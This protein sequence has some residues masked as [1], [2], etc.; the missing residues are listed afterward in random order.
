MREGWAKIPSLLKI[1]TPPRLPPERVVSTEQLPETRAEVAPVTRPPR[2]LSSGSRTDTQ[3]LHLEFWTQFHRYMQSRNATIQIS[4]PSHH[5]YSHAPLGR[6]NFQLSLVNDMAGGRTRLH[7]DVNGPLRDERFARLK[8]KHKDEL[9]AK[10]GKLKW[11]DQPPQVRVERLSTP[12]A[13]STWPELNVWL[14]DNLERWVA[15][16]R[17][18]VASL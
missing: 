8:A 12:S 18:I 9:E 10:L 1:G 4:K 2:T 15:A 17:P 14:G 16:L 5:H 11:I 7:F 13:R 6:S 3:Q